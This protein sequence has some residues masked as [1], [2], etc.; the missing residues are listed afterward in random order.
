MRYDAIA[1]ITATL[2]IV[3]ITGIY[4]VGGLLLAAYVGLV[5]PPQMKHWS[6]PPLT[7]AACSFP[8]AIAWC[9]QLSHEITI[10]ASVVS[11]P[12]LRKTSASI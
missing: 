7:L 2:L 8:L 9:H 12:S 10:Y 11:H 6:I 5:F 3:L 1:E 4:T